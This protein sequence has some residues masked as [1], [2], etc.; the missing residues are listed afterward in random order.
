LRTFLRKYVDSQVSTERRTRKRVID[1][2][3]ASGETKAPVHAPKWAIS[4]YGGTLKEAVEAAS[5]DQNE[6][7]RENNVDQAEN[8]GKGGQDTDDND[9]G[10]NEKA[11]K[12]KRSRSL[13]SEVYDSDKGS[14]E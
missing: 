1:T 13:V 4:G 8:E 12:R 14:S 9:A 11:E 3:F 10:D 5:K 7:D 6:A 2:E